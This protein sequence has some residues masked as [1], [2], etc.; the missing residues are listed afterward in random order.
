MD[1]TVR[2]QD[3]NAII[4]VSGKLDAVTA[5]D[6]EARIAEVLAGTGG[7]IVLNLKDLEYIS[8]AGLR[9]ILS[10]AKQLKAKQKDLAVVAL[11]GPVKRVF[12]ISGF[13]AFVKA[14]D[15][16]QDALNAQG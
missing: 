11:Q 5:P 12:E 6:L 2:T 16:E 7:S 13:Y 9:V 10:T 14:F 8:S 4:D 15:T 1:V 3:D